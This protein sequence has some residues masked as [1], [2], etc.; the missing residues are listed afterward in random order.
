MNLRGKIIAVDFDGTIVEH[1]YPSIGLAV[2][3]AF[4]ALKEFQEAGAHLVLLT[5]RSDYRKDHAKTEGHPLREAVEFCR[6]HG[7]EF[8]AVNENPEQG[9]W[10]GSP[11]VYAHAYIDDAAIGCPLRESRRAGNTR[12]C[13]DWEKMRV[14]VAERLAPK[15]P[16]A[17]VGE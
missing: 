8:W 13:V 3:G 4:E 14:L 10:T 15:A 1:E 6:A 2:P 7:L 11:K 16:L 12:P 5:M 17:T 9:L